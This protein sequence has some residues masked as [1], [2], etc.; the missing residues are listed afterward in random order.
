[1]LRKDKLHANA[2]S[3]EVNKV[4]SDGVVILHE[5]VTMTKLEEELLTEFGT[6]SCKVT[7]TEND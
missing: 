3:S 7:I 2:N 4:A 1:M 6:D 5:P